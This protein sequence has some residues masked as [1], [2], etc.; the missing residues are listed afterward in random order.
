MTR[1]IASFGT[2]ADKAALVAA[3]ARTHPARERERGGGA[4]HLVHDVQVAPVV[5]LDAGDDVHAAMTAVRDACRAAGGAEPVHLEPDTGL[6]LCTRQVR[7]VLNV[8][9]VDLSIHGPFDGEGIL[10]AVIDGGIDASHPDLDGKIVDRWTGYRVQGPLDA[11]HGTMIAGLSC[12]TGAMSDEKHAGIAPGA[13]L[14]D[15]VVFDA[16]G[17]GWISDLIAA[18][19]IAASRG[20]RIACMACTA[21]PGTPTSRALAT[22]MDTLAT[23]R[24]VH[25]CCAAGNWGTRAGIGQPGS[26][27]HAITTA[28]V[29]P[30]FDVTAFSTR[31]EPGG[32]HPDLALPGQDVISLNVETSPWKDMPLDENEHY[33]QFTG[34]SVSVGILAGIVAKV[35][36]WRDMDPATLKA[37]ITG[38][39][40]PVSGAGSSAAGAGL[41]DLERLFASLGGFHPVRATTSGIATSGLRIAALLAISVATLAMM[42][43]SFV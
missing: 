12:G 1:W 22:V 17:R 6:V 19:D 20:A 23:A 14:L 31:G 25:L 38:S 5:I 40:R 16:A 3:V 35:L 15:L 18:L 26:D 29:T 21:E 43:A 28:S 9:V 7:T 32:R 34:N 41:P 27:V 36:S 24:R 13:T 33:A 4:V 30:R 37:A 2:A 39:C 11:G 8:D 42:L 10:I